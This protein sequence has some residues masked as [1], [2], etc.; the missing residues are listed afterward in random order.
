M[1]IYLLL[2]V[3]GALAIMD[4][5]LPAK[6]GSGVITDVTEIGSMVRN[7]GSKGHMMYW[8]SIKL[9]TG[10]KIWTQRTANNFT[11]GDSMDVDLSAVLG[12]VVRYR[13]YRPSYRQWYETEGQKEEYRPFPFA[14]VLFAL[15]LLYPA[16]STENRML[17]RGILVVILIAWLIV[18]LASGN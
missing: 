18:M 14:M 5:Y 1:L 9:D 12:K 7:K 17:L 15:L 2:I 3:V 10:K 13:G 11:V 8:S 6:R 16:W 4:L